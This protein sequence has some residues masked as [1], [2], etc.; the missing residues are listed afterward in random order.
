MPLNN[1][2]NDNESRKFEA[3]PADQVAV[4]VLEKGSRSIGILEGISYVGLTRELNT[5]TR[6]IYRFYSDAGLTALVATVT[7]DYTD[8]TLEF[9]SQAVRT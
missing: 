9:I 6:E 8:A 7:V 5:P 2:V 3:T 1:A 4:R